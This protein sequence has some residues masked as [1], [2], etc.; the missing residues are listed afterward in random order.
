VH[1]FYY[2]VALVVLYFLLVP[3]ALS[4]PERGGFGSPARNTPV[5]SKQVIENA[6]RG[7]HEGGSYNNNFATLR[8]YSRG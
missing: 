8:T 6:T 7:H 4:T 1:A 2:E 3:P 5:S